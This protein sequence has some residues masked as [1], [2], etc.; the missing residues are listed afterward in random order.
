MK[1]IK[2]RI[3]NQN[4]VELKRVQDA[5]DNR[6][7]D[8]YMTVSVSV[9]ISPKRTEPV[10]S[11]IVLLFAFVRKIATY[12]FVDVA[13]KRVTRSLDQNAKMWAM[14]TDISKQC[15]RQVF[16]IEQ[17]RYIDKLITPEQWKIIF[18]AHQRNQ[19][20]AI[21]IDGQIVSFGASTSRMTKAELAELIELMY[22]F[23]ADNDVNWS[24][25]AAI[26]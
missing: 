2:I 11:K 26:N 8:S 25:K 20:T 21:G 9:V 18:T 22:A 14:L 17:G 23:G 1:A 5:L 3:E 19:T 13:F 10:S 12:G 24:E 6:P 4:S 7:S 16:D 15:E